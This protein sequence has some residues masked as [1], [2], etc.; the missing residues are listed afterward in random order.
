MEMTGEG[1]ILLIW[2]NLMNIIYNECY[3]IYNDDGMCSI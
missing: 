3:V 2:D 1:M